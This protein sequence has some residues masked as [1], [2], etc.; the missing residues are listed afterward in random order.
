MQKLHP[1]L[2]KLNEGPLFIFFSGLV[3]LS[4]LGAIWMEE[5]TILVLPVAMV[6]VFATIVNF[7]AVFYTLFALLPLSI[8]TDLPGGIGTDFPSELLMVFL[9]LCTIFYFLANPQKVDKPFFNHTLTKLLL[10]HLVWIGI[11]A[12][13]SQIF[14]ISIKFFL[15]KIWY[16]TVFFFLA[17]HFIKNYKDFKPAFWAL[18]IALAAVIIRTLVRHSFHGFDFENVN[19]T[20][21]PFFR[22]HVNYA[23]MLTLWTPFLL[24][25]RYWYK[26]GSIPRFAINISLVLVMA[27]IFFAYTR[28]AYVSLL[29]IPIG[30]LIFDR[31][32]AKT[33]MVS[34]ALLLVLG[35][36]YLGLGSKYL[37][38]A[39][40]FEK[41]VYH[42]DF[43][44]H[45][46]A[47]LQLQDLSTMER[48]HRWIAGVRMCKDHFL[49]G[50]GPGTFFHFY[51]P[52]TDAA[53]ETYVSDNEDQSTVHNYF[54]LILIEQ[55]GMGFVLFLVL[56][57]VFFLEGQRI[58]H[59]TQDPMER[60]W[61]MT[62]LLVML[63]IMANIFMA[64]L[65][66]TDEIGSLFF[67]S[68][69]L[70]I[71]QDIKNKQL[72]KKKI[73]R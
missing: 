73:V 4:L 64:D 15:A 67:L 29:L 25:A 23:V 22:N 12:V 43:D 26:S 65:I 8:E 34:A 6:L 35:L 24:F 60:K 58:Y 71:N 63:M 56:C 57:I 69:A 32:L 61:V 16:I 39:P 9:M 20:M 30:Y 66:E 68:F 7:R 37:T 3:L 52:Y 72:K 36:G 49:S 28:A 53:F 31:K 1:L 54:L 62:Q 14:F 18:T 38:F 45:L 51:K 41:T 2:Q 46:S 48:F 40:D 59:E 11:S 27:G 17:G 55:G 70:L 50:F 19:R 33:A 10:I 42:T 21:G 44:D 47:T 5:Y 13:L